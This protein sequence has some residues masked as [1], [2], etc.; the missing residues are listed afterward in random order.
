MWTATRSRSSSRRRSERNGALCNMATVRVGAEQRRVDGAG[1][2][3]ADHPKRQ[4][5]RSTEYACDGAQHTDLIGSPRAPAGKYDTRFVRR[6]RH[7]EVLLGA[8][9]SIENHQRRCGCA[10]DVALTKRN[11]E[12]VATDLSQHSE[13]PLLVRWVKQKR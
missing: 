9:G 8:Q 2:C 1:R 6:A 12:I 13:V 5:R 3:P 4:W 10:P 7:A 11:R